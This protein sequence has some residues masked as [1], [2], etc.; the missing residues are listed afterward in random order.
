MCRDT[1]ECG[2][3][4]IKVIVASYQKSLTYSRRQR[5]WSGTTS[6]RS[7]WWTHP[8][9]LHTS[10]KWAGV[11]TVVMIGHFAVCQSSIML[12]NGLGWPFRSTPLQRPLILH[13]QSAMRIISRVAEQ[14]S[15]SLY[16][17]ICIHVSISKR[18]GSQ[19]STLRANKWVNVL[20]CS[21]CRCGAETS[22]LPSRH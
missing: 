2:R 13:Q 5:K 9:R 4:R 1:N 12:W 16:I 17:F 8:G 11:S 14:M 19:P 10:L 18:N 6:K 22:T 3:T 20:C 15:A 7:V 21:Y